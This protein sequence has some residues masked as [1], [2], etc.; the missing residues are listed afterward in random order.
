MRTSC[1]HCGNNMRMERAIYYEY[2]RNIMKTFVKM[3]EHEN[4]MTCE[5]NGNIKTSL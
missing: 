2:Q 5:H 4:I 1:E 3:W